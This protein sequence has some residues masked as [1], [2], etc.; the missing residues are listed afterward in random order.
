MNFLMLFLRGVGILPSLIEGIE[1]LYGSKTGAQKK[2]AA[3]EIVQTAINVADAV[4]AKQ[5]MDAAGFTDGLGKIVD[6]VVAC[7]NASMWN[8]S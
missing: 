5:I 6:G 4:A 8:K 1:S 2:S 7:L 3:L